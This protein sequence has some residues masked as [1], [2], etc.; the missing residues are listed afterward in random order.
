[1]RKSVLCRF[2]VLLSLAATACQP[3]APAAPSKP[4]PAAPAPAAPAPAAPAASPAATS[5]A[6]APPKPVA[7]APTATPAA[8]DVPRGGTLV[9]ALN[10]D[11]DTI[12]SSLNFGTTSVVGCK[13][14]EGLLSVN[15]T[16]TTFT[17]EL[18]ESWTFTPDGL[19]YTFKLRQGVVFHDGTPFTSA[20]VK[21]SFENVNQYHPITRRWWTSLQA[22]ETP[23]PQ[24]VTIKLKDSFAPLLA[25]LSCA[26]G[27][28]ITAKSMAPA[29]GEARADQ[30]VNQAPIGTGPFMIKE[31]VAGDRIVL[32]KN[33]KYWK[34]NLPYLD[35][36]VIRMVPDTTSMVLALRG[37]ELNYIDQPFV[38][39]EAIIRYR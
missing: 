27:G 15:D 37:G 38:E 24:T 16:R 34:Q 22:I 25:S 5:T 30:K 21:W 33:D 10:A 26:D 2:V 7:A 31:R 32:A 28:A 9:T 36:I 20:D 29:S 13:I 23:D 3:A 19:S 12:N 8:A 6:V 35:Q 39:N 11:P 1:M 17:P 14:Q 4:A 18:A